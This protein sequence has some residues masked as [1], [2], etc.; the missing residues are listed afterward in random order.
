MKSHIS[1]QSRQQKS[2]HR[3]LTSRNSSRQGQS[4][5]EA[6]RFDRKEKLDQDIF[7]LHL[8]GYGACG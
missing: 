4:I 1:R 8:L 7:D 5:S 3:R 6:V 2:K